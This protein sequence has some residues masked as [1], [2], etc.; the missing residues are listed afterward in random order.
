MVRSTGWNP[1]P[2]QEFDIEA[3]AASLDAIVMGRAT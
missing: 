2:P 1:Y 3:F